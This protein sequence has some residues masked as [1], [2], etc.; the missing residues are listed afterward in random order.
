[1]GGEA[2]LPPEADTYLNNRRITIYL[3]R[4]VRIKISKFLNPA[5]QIF[6]KY[7]K[8]SFNSPIAMYSTHV[9]SLLIQHLKLSRL[10]GSVPFEFDPNSGKII[11]MKSRKGRLI[12]QLQS[13]MTLTYVLGMVYNVFL[14]ELPVLKKLQG[15]PFIIAYGLLA[16]GMECGTR[17]R[18]G[19]SGQCS[20]RL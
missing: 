4:L 5:I 6:Q 8:T 16:P 13:I 2:Y 17:H 9:I 14:G 18:S 11:L 1:M 15:F 19:S 20:S 10:I 3:C 12:V 7:T